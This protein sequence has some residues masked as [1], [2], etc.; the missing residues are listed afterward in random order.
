MNECD[1][2]LK[3]EHCVNVPAGSPTIDCGCMDHELIGTGVVFMT[4][5]VDYS[6]SN[7]SGHP[8]DGH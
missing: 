8:C 1:L 2:L 4:R 7:L 3:I 6:E 5:R